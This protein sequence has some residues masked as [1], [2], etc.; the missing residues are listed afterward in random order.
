MQNNRCGNGMPLH[1]I[2]EVY[3]LV[4][5]KPKPFGGIH[6]VCWGVVIVGRGR[7]AGNHTRKRIDALLAVGLQ[8]AVN[9]R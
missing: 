9:S 6:D 8:I 3:G 1:R 2:A 5:I 7:P 4:R